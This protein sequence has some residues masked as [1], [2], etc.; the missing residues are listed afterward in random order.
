MIDVRSIIDLRSRMSREQARKMISLIM[1]EH[2]EGIKFS[3]H[4]EQRFQE[5]G[6][7]RIDVINVLAA[8]KIYI[9]AEWADPGW[10][11]M[12]QTKKI[13]VVIAFVNPFTVIVITAWRNE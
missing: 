7:L 13:T 10:R 5:R 1:K 8:G 4:A 9:D 2:R 11:Y 6:L 3:Y 12:V